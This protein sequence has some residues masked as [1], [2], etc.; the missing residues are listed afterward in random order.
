ME[1]IHNPTMCKITS[2]SD[3]KIQ[4]SLPQH[5]SAKIA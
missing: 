2:L 5:Y 3:E 4:C 1:N